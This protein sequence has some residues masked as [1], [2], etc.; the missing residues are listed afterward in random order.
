MAV[1][2]LRP[3]GSTQAPVVPWSLNAGTTAV[4]MDAVLDDGLPANGTS[5]ATSGWD[6]ATYL[7][8][9]TGTNT[10]AQRIEFG[11]FTIP[12][13]A[14][15]RSVQLRYRVHFPS[16]ISGDNRYYRVSLFDAAAQSRVA[17]D[18]YANVIGSSAVTAHNG[19]VFTTNSQGAAWTQANISALA[20]SIQY[21][22]GTTGSTSFRLTELYAD[23]LYNEAPTATVTAPA[24]GGTVGTTRPTITW[25]YADPENDLQERYQ[26]K[27]FS[28]AQYTDPLFNVETSTPIFDSGVV[29]DSN[30]RSVALNTDLI[31]TIV[32]RAYVRVAD[33]GSSGRYSNWDYNQFTVTLSPATTP[34]ITATILNNEGRIRLDVI[35]SGDVGSHAILEYSDDAGETW[36]THR[37]GDVAPMS[38]P[39][40]TPA[41]SSVTTATTGGTLADATAYSYKVTAL[42]GNGETVPS[43][44]GTVTTG[45]GPT[46]T[47]ST[48][49]NWGAVAGATGYKVY[50]R[51]S[52]AWGLLATL[53]L[54]TTWTDTGA[55]A[56]GAAPPT[57]GTTRQ[58]SIYDDEAR[59]LT[60]RMYRA[61]ATDAAATLTS[62]PSGTVTATLVLADWW[63]KD[64][65]APQ[66]NRSVW[67]EGREIEVTYPEE[68]A[69][70]LPLGRARKVILKGDIRGGEFP[71]T[72][73]TNSRA[74][75]DA[76]DALRNRQ[77]TLFL[78]SPVGDQWYVSITA[79]QVVR[80]SF[81]PNIWRINAS[82]V[83]VDAP[84]ETLLAQDIFVLDV[85]LLG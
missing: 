44:E 53:G 56:P 6:D 74:Q 38:S 81:S 5:G 76:L 16:W 66:L 68:I 65:L 83:E 49:V 31:N 37:A 9:D 4:A 34:S 55:D 57:A 18:I 59:S 24:E 52:G 23:V 71:V 85:S 50:G 51:I 17:D 11:T 62:A 42:L 26:V 40:A 79:W 22:G 14:Q 70:F 3:S 39:L 19:G 48:T 45:A 41:I 1:I 33:V 8:H 10:A 82:M 69:E 54:V 67:V 84:G 47:H 13:L 29:Y 73:F 77:S 80:H 75:R 35:G 78:Q 7:A 2:T 20:A 43:A 58:I 12:V 28:E 21:W 36:K 25:D 15:I 46:G 60:A 32:Y 30:A 61:R 27:V 63:L 72:F 64:P